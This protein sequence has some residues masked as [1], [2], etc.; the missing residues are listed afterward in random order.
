MDRPSPE[1]LYSHHGVGDILLYQLFSL[2]AVIQ[3]KCIF[4][5]LLR[6]HDNRGGMI[7]AVQNHLAVIVCL[8]AFDVVLPDLP[9]LVE[10]FAGNEQVVTVGEILVNGVLQENII[11]KIFPQTEDEVTPCTG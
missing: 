11:A 9:L 10:P 3:I 8:A 2:E 6:I 4:G 1:K 7:E 5:T